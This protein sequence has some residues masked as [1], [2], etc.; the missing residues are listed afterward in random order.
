MVLGIIGILSVVVVTSHA[1]FNKTLLLTYT[2]YDVALTIRSAETF[3]L[4]TRA[5]S[6][7][8]RIG[9]G[10]HFTQ[11]SNTFT[12]FSDGDR[13]P[14][15]CHPFR[16]DDAAA[17]DPD[18]VQ[19]DCAYDGSGELSPDLSITPY[20]LGNGM[21]ISEACVFSVGSWACDHPVDIVFARPN[22]QAFFAYNGLYDEAYTKARITIR[23]QQNTLSYVCVGRIGEIRVTNT[24]TAC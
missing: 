19:G 16:R 2:A 4:G 9:Y 8:T 5:T 14:T 18:T 7:D 20:T 6:D 21:K 23:S 3:G 10:L 13:S 12:L 22:T 11:D 24:N 15:D 17:D 1:T